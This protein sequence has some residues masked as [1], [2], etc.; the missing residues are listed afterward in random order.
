MTRLTLSNLSPD[1]QEEIVTAL[2]DEADATGNTD[3]LE[4]A[5]AGGDLLGDRDPI[6][7]PPAVRNRIGAALTRHIDRTHR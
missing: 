7:V 5:L 1:T 3:P 4:R 2:A 6:H